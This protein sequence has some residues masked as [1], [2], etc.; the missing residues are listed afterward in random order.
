MRAR[1][2]L[3][4]AMKSIKGKKIFFLDPIKSNDSKLIYYSRKYA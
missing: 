1:V 4:L 2:K 3:T